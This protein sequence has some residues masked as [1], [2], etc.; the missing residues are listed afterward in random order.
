[1]GGCAV[2]YQTF[3]I[4]HNFRIEVVESAD[5]IKLS[6][7]DLKRVEAVWEQEKQLKG[8]RLFDGRL[9]CY[10]E[11][12]GDY[13][14][15][16]FISYKIYLAVLKDPTL[17]AALPIKALGISG[18]TRSGPYTLWGKRASFV[19]GFAGFYE[20][21]PSGGL[22]HEMVKG[23]NIRVEEPFIQ[24][25]TEETGIQHRSIKNIQPLALVF[26]DDASL[27]EVIA[28]IEV[29]SSLAKGKLSPSDEYEELLWVSDSDQQTFFNSHSGKI[30]PMSHYLLTSGL[31]SM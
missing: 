19:S 20:C 21:A 5:V 30:L 16:A 4:D 7:D 27:F 22:S 15:G 6:D 29:D 1:M 12:G 23:G 3:M 28:S 9:L 26:D 24:E 13:L 2:N 8:D 25:L 18:I 14:R 31:L 10:I 11:H 17:R